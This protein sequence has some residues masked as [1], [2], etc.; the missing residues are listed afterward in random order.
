MLGLT[1]LNVYYDFLQ[2]ESGKK[3][4]VP[5]NYTKSCN[6]DI[7]QKA[8]KTNGIAQYKNDL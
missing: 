7:F 8:T 1:Q 4:R 3:Q 2:K 6:T 5:K